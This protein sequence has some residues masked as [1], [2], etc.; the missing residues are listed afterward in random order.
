MPPLSSSRSKPTATP[1]GRPPSGDAMRVLLDACAASRRVQ[2][3]LATQGH[4]VLSAL[5]RN[6]RASDE[7]LL[8]LAMDERRIL[9]AEDFLDVGGSFTSEERAPD[10]RLV[11]PESCRLRFVR[12][13]NS[14]D[15]T[16][17][18]SRLQASWPFPN[19]CRR[20]PTRPS[21]P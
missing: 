14:G 7:E 6:P 3:A 13:P 17:V 16:T 12:N 11:R 18:G 15:E 21:P 5:E 4:H 10:P 1:F 2:D 9:V 20:A 8:A 19:H